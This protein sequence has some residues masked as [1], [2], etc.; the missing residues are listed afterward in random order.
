[1]SPRY[2]NQYKRKQN[3]CEGP[4]EV[5]HFLSNAA[6]EPEDAEGAKG[7]N[8]LDHNIAKITV[9]KKYKKLLLR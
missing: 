9:T 6:Q 7:M 8:T 2:I 1:V 3:N 5:F 4:H